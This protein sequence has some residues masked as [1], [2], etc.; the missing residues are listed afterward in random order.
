MVWEAMPSRWRRRRILPG[1]FPVIENGVNYA[2]G[3]FLDGLRVGDPSIG[4]AFRNAKPGDVIALFATGLAPSPAGVLVSLQTV[5]GVTVTIGTVTVPA[6]FA[7]LVAVGEFQINFTVPQQFASLPAGELSAD[8]CGE[9]SV[10]T[11]DDRFES[12]ERGSAADSAL[13]QFSRGKAYVFDSE[14]SWL[15]R[16]KPPATSRSRLGPENCGAGRYQPSL[17]SPRRANGRDPR[18]NPITI[19]GQITGS[20]R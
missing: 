15:S 4:P 9:W 6:D 14:I 7:G 8:H 11:G 10:V 12:A 1:I 17:R 18:K 16:E 20:F 3:V 2:G 13:K 19:E 5:S